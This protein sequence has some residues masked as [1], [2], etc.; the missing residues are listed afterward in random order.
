MI[1]ITVN[2]EGLERPEGS[3]VATLLA[4]LGMDKDRVAVELDGRIVRRPDWAATT[5]KAGSRLEIV[6][7]VGGG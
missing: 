2:G 1:G 6:Q 4:S 7:F 5:L 3:T